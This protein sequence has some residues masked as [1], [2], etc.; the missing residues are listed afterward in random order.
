M[1]EEQSGRRGVFPPLL[2]LKDADY[3]EH[4]CPVCRAARRGSRLAKIVQAIEL[5]ITFGGCP[6]GRA[7][8]RKY[9]VKPNEPLPPTEE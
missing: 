7:R 9:G 4:G 2:N 5:A 1:S 6:W 8:E 3:C